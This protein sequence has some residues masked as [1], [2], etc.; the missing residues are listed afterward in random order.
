MGAALQG[1]GQRKSIWDEHAEIAAAIA[2]GDSQRAGELS[3]HH[4]R[5]ASENLVRRIGE[6]LSD[7]AGQ[8]RRS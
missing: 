4:T 8:P 7:N 3:E 2:E 1:S 5:M 6:V